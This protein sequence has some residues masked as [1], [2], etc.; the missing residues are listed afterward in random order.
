MWYF[1]CGVDPR[2]YFLC[3]TSCVALTPGGTSCVV[4][5]VQAPLNGCRCEP[6][7]SKLENQL[8]ATREEVRTEIQTTQDLLNTKLSLMERDNQQ[9]VHNYRHTTHTQLQ[10]HSTHTTRDTQHTHN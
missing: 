1:L 8:E 5:P 4:L 9:Q 6:L 3:G 2:R 10:T 7:L